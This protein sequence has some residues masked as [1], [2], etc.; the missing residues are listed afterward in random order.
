M[1]GLREEWTPDVERRPGRGDYVVGAVASVVTQLVALVVLLLVV[2]VVGLGIAG[3]SGDADVSG[4]RRAVILVLGALAVTAATLAGS[5]VG[6]W[7]LMRRGVGEA[8]A[9]RVAAVLAGVVGLLLLVADA[10]D[11]TALQWVAGLLAT[12]AGAV[13]GARSAP[14]TDDG[15]H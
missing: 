6:A 3:T 7:V 12:A 1:A 14:R 4:A 5:W 2:G 15:H 13:L 11:K 8:G 9:R 10:G